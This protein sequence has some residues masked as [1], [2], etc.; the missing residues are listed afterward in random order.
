M[1]GL[2]LVNRKVMQ[3]IG[4]QRQPVPLVVHIERGFLYV[5]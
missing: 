3:L 4:G 1:T 2:R 5:K